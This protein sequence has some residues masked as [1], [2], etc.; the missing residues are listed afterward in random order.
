MQYKWIDVG[1]APKA[2]LAQ[3]SFYVLFHV[4]IFLIP[5]VVPYLLRGTVSYNS[6]L[7]SMQYK[8]NESLWGFDDRVLRITISKLYDYDIIGQFLRVGFLYLEETRF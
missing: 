6:R 3:Q 1:W 5:P 2:T 4:L 7:V 8:I